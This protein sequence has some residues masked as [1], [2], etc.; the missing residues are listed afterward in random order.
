MK[1]KIGIGCLVQWYEADIIGEYVESLKDAIKNYDGEI[2]VDFTIVKNQDLEKCISQE[3]LDECIEKIKSICNI[4]KAQSVSIQATEE[5]YTIAD[6]RREFNEEYCDVVDVL[7]WGESDSLIPKQ[8]FKILDSLHNTSLQNNN[9]KYLAFFGGCKMWDDSWK[10]LEHPDFT[11]KPFLEG[12][13]KN[14][15]SLRYTMNKEEMDKIN[16]KTENLD[17]QIVSPHKFNGCGLVISSEVIR[18]GVNIPKSVFFIHEDSA[19]MWMTNK[20]L[21]NIPQY[22]VKNILLVHNRKSPKKRVH[23]AGEE[24]ID[25]TDLGAQRRTHDW[26]MKANS[27][28][29]QN[30][31]NLFNPNWKSFT[32]RDV[33]NT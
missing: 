13:T 19:F 31:Q 1:T 21:G 5:L 32:W 24:G 10:Q 14:W 27:M 28:C 4:Y 29:E 20:V 12:D 22:I 18:A 2:F 9:P 33:F 7:M 25:K 3:K 30:Y 26:Y 11:D 23:I 15:W 17:V 8:T 6:Y 16:E